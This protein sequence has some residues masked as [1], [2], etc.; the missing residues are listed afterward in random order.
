[1]KPSFFIIGIPRS[2]TTTLYH[3]LSQHPDIFMCHPKEPNY[4]NKD[5]VKEALAFMP[6]DKAFPFTKTEEDY[7]KLFE[8]K[9][10]NIA[11]E[12]TINYFY[13]E[14]APEEIKKFNPEAKLILI[15]REP[16]S[17][18]ESFYN[19]LFFVGLEDSKTF[20]QAL[21]SERERKLGKNIPENTRYPSQLFYSEKIRYTQHIK[22]WLKHFPKEQIK[23]I[24]YDDF[25]ED[26]IKVYKEILNFL[27]LESTFTP[28]IEWTNTK[29]KLRKPSLQKFSSK[30]SS[31]N[32]TIQNILPKSL[33][34]ELKKI[35]DSLLKDKSKKTLSPQLKRELKDKYKKEV[36]ELSQFLD[37]DLITLWGY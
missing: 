34:K 19:Q 8:N 16:V 3:Y 17:F 35:Y 18:L 10:G 4:F 7:L 25:K 11:G 14:K 20:S 6:K 33:Y 28:K 26:N 15:L 2:G 32:R 30:I 37:K 9:E 27:E 31:Q 29:K 21:D 24:L 12:A 23:I 22:I 13:S 5:N 36:E 1:M